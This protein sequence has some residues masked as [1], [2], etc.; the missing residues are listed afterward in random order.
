MSYRDKTLCFD[1]S[2][3]GAFA[4]M[5]ALLATDDTVQLPPGAE[6]GD[7]IDMEVR[8]CSVLCCAYCCCSVAAAA[9]CV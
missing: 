8:S 3:V 5:G 1:V 2:P 6:E 4:L 9:A 7:D